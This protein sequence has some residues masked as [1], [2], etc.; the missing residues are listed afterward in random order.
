MDAANGDP[1][2]EY[3]FCPPGDMD[4]EPHEVAAKALEQL[5]DVF[6]WS[7]E[8]TEG[9]MQQVRNSFQT[10]VLNEAPATT[11]EELAER[12]EQSDRKA[13]IDRVLNLAAAAR[14]AAGDM[15]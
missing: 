2:H 13:A 4:G 15:T 10:M 9:T 6:G 11:A 7:A 3:L 12:W 1:I 5:R 14:R 8:L